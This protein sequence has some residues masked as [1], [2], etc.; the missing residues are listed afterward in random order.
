M[1][2][3]KQIRDIE[4]PEEV[5]KQLTERFKLLQNRFL[6][7][8]MDYK[9]FISSEIKDYEIYNLRDNVL[10]R[11]YSARF[12]FQLLLEY[13]YRV[14]QRLKELFNRNPEELFQGGFELMAIKEQSTKEIYSLFDSM[15]YHLC[16]IYDYLF[17]LINYTHGKE[18]LD[19]PK[20]NRF[21]DQKNQKEFIYCSKELIPVLEKIDKEFVYPL[22][23]HRSH[24]IHTQNDTGDFTLTFNLGEDKIN[25][26]FFATKLFRQNFSE[27]QVGNE[28]HE[29][30][31]KY[32]GFWLIDKTIKTIT[33][34]LFELREDMIRNKRI[35]HGMFVLLGPDNS[36]QPASSPWWGDRNIS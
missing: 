9:H 33:E 26:S 12:H 34:A 29:L 16:S 36:I 22:I 27:I 30:T 7:I 10:Y 4:N 6:A 21:R 5:F 32:A 18:I 1:E 25:T 17:R 23:G 2:E 13:H 15:M 11:L 28:N 20:W 19:K 31:I 8:A 3:R 35:P 24:L 14:E